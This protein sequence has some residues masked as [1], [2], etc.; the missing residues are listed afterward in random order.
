MENQTTLI[1]LF[2]QDENLTNGLR[3][4]GAIVREL[5]RCDY[6]D[7]LCA[8]LADTDASYFVTVDAQDGFSAADVLAVDAA[9]KSD[10]SKVYAGQRVLPEK[11]SPAQLL[12]GMLSG[13]VLSDV[14]AGLY[15]L[16]REHA[17]LVAHAK[18]RDKAFFQNIPLIARSNG[19]GVEGVQATDAAAQA[20]GFGVLAS[21][22][23]LYGVFIKFSIAALI[24]YLV[25]IGTFYLF[26]KLFFAL[27]D[28]FKVLASTVLS[29]ILCSVATYLLNKGA[30]FNSQAKS[31]GTAVRFVILAVA[32]LIASWLLVWSVGSLLGGG[33]EINTILKVVVD[34]VIF[35]ASFTIQR[36]WVFKESKGLLK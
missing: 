34:L 10:A 23:R 14:A 36:D 20:P 11:K 15:G 30:V 1:L 4:S 28:E 19:I 8:A 16:S 33:D 32:Q 18:S 22:M 29:R 26:Q 5:P 21:S 31:A 9:L 35:L 2:G 24:A 6:C 12:Y 27:E 17:T 25:D 3:A 7:S 13:L